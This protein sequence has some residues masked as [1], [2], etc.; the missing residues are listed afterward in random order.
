[1]QNVW[2][3]ILT[4]TEMLI[5]RIQMSWK[6]LQQLSSCYMWI[7]RHTDLISTPLELILWH[8][9]VKAKLTHFN[10]VLSNRKFLGNRIKP[11]RFFLMVLFS[12]TACW[13]ECS[14]TKTMASIFH[15]LPTFLPS[16]PCALNISVG[17]NSPSEKSITSK[18]QAKFWSEG[19]M[20]S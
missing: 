12:S 7:N 19:N 18:W 15:S 20:E 2:Y 9:K 17:W 10:S 4:I 5:F 6:S 1:M 11:D 8:T 16:F 13:E 14:F 3:S